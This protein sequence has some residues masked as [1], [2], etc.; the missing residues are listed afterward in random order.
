MARYYFDIHDGQHQ[1]RD[2]V[3]TECSSSDAVR[4]EAMSAL[5]AIARDV[6]PKDGDRQAL[7]VIVRNARNLT[8]YTA[9]M[10]FASIWLGEDAPFVAENP[11]Q[12]EHSP[13]VW[14]R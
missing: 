12:E 7:T 4:A 9:T 2:D 10:T 8:V 14:G 1:T 11:D 6:I 5:P 3:G 13:I